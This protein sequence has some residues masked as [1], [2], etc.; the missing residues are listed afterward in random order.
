MVPYLMGYKGKALF[1]D[2]DMMFRWDVAELFDIS[3][4]EAVSV[5]P[6][7]GR[8]AFER[9]SVMMFNCEKCKKLTPEYI[10]DPNSNPF[11]FNWAD[12]IGELPHAWN[13]LVGYDEPDPDAKLVHFTQGIPIFQEVE[14]CEFEDEFKTELDMSRSSVSWEAIMGGSVHKEAVLSKKKRIIV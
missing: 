11:D 8:L 12:S 7:K 10:N 4:D 1:I 9:P 13:H 2:S 6:F 3:G 5:V 14:G